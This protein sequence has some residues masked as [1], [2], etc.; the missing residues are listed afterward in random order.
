MGGESVARAVRAG[1]DLAQALVDRGQQ[2][3][4]SATDEA[5]AEHHLDRLLR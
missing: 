3:L 1:T 4:V 5:A 2:P